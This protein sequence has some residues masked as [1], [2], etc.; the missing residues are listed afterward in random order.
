MQPTAKML[1]RAPAPAIASLSAAVV[2]VF[3]KCIEAR[4]DFGASEDA[5]VIQKWF[6]VKRSN[7][8]VTSE[9]GKVRCELSGHELGLKQVW[10]TLHFVS[11]NTSGEASSNKSSAVMVSLALIWAMPTLRIA[12][13][14]IPRLLLSVASYWEP[15]IGTALMS[16]KMFPSTMSVKALA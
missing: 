1:I 2:T 15:A 9:R 13:Q 7:T 6:K 10:E 11:L 12:S 5:R 14:V 3:I 16:F 8:V 4:R